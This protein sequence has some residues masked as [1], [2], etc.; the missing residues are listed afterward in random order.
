[1][2]CCVA[3]QTAPLN[4]GHPMSEARLHHFL[5]NPMILKRCLLEL[6]LYSIP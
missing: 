3:L 1:M 5:A 2:V 6:T 4:D